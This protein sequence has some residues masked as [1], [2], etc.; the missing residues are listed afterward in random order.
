MIEA[1]G[2]ES[3]ASDQRITQYERV[4]VPD[5]SIP[6]YGQIADRYGSKNNQGSDTFFHD[7]RGRFNKVRLQF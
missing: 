1:F 3:P 7:E 4:V 2:D 6:R 5:E